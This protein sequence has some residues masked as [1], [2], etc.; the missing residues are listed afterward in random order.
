MEETGLGGEDD[1]ERLQEK[2]RAAIEFDGVN[3]EIDAS[4]IN[5]KGKMG[6]MEET[7]NLRAPE[8]DRPNQSQRKSTS[9]SKV[10][11][12]DR[13]M[14]EKRYGKHVQSDSDPVVRATT[15]LKMRGR[16]ARDLGMSRS[17]RQPQKK[18]KHED[19]S[20]KQASANENAKNDRGAKWERARKPWLNKFFRLAEFLWDEDDLL[21]EDREKENAEREKQCTGESTAKEE[22]KGKQRVRNLD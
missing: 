5:E 14:E 12:V 6:Q 19:C 3:A 16:K 7:G 8:E 13:R 20:G 4:L 22:R 21:Q 11:G 9:W 2:G 17:S 15:S 10:S 18:R 1:V